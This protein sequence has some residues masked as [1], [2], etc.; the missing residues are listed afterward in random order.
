MILS[1]I[2]NKTIKRTLERPL[3]EVEFDA[4][5]TADI[6]SYKPDL[7]NF[8]Y[9]LEHAEQEL[10]VPWA[11]ILHTAQSLRADHM[12]AKQMGIVSTWIHREDDRE[13]VEQLR[14]VVNPSWRFENMQEMAQAVENEAG[15]S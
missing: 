6:G 13:Q 11:E 3:K 5:Y 9:L 14:N 7:K 15:K 8:H 10:R 2:D 1:N 12:P 4:I